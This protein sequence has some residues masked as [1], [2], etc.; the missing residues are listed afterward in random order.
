MSCSVLVTV[1]CVEVVFRL[2]LREIQETL[3]FEVGKAA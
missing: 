3:F 1:F 2:I